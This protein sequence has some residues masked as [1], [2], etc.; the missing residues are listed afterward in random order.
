MSV[1][2]RSTIMAASG[3]EVN[4]FYDLGEELGRGAFAVVY[5]ATEKSSGKKYAVKKILKN[6]MSHPEVLVREV[7]VLK[8]TSSKHAGINTLVDLFEDEETLYLVL[9]FVAGGELFDHIVE[10]GELCLSV[11][12]LSVF[13]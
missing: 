3:R 8:E 12:C 9:D 6:K 1:S 10:A 2:A 4:D 5:S 13:A 7:S 11:C